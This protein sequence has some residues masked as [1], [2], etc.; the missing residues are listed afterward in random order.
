MLM[1]DFLS[2]LNSTINYHYEINQMSAF[3]F[4]HDICNSVLVLISKAA[5][6]NYL[7]LSY[8]YYQV[9]IKERI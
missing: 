6:L 4:L 9:Y 2:R 8:G 7:I 3:Y 1:T 5:I